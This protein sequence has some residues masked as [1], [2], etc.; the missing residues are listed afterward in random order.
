MDQF[1]PELIVQIL[2]RLG[3]R[4]LPSVRCVCRQFRELID[5]TYFWHFKFKLDFPTSLIDT[6][7]HGHGYRHHVSSSRL[8][9]LH[10]L[11]RTGG[12]ERGSEIFI[13]LSTC[14]DRVIMQNDEALLHYFIGQAQEKIDI[15]GNQE[16][17]FLIG[18]IHG[19]LKLD[20]EL[21]YHISWFTFNRGLVYAAH[22]HHYPLVKRIM[23]TA[24]NWV[25][26]D[27]IR[28]TLPAPEAELVL[29]WH[30][31]YL[32]RADD[33]EAIRDHSGIRARFS[34]LIRSH[35]SCNLQ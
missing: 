22:R 12:C 10:Q 30:R 7:W 35:H 26:T 3:Y 27:Y 1:P 20:P 13:A 31:K 23:Q 9:Y 33:Q 5:S 29:S 25:H 4:D 16:L 17:K 32:Q 6:F 14:M 2:S 11:T 15:D 34:R 8:C 24:L 28:K 18:A 19:H 21:R